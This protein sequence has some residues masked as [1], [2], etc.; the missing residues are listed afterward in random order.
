MAR[1]DDAAPL[2]D[3]SVPARVPAIASVLV[4]LGALLAGNLL[5]AVIVLV[6]VAVTR[7]PWAEVGIKRWPHW[8]RG[9]FMAIGAGALLKVALKV[10]V[11]PPL[12]M[13]PVNAAYHALTG[14]AAALPGILFLVV[15]GGGFGEELIWRGFLFERLRALLGSSPSARLLIVVFSSLLFGLAHL[16]DQGWP[17]VVQATITGAVFGAAFLRLSVIWPVMIAHASFDLTGV[18][19]IYF[20]REEW[21]ARLVWR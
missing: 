10:L 15:V 13:P 21:F 19:M 18:V 3:S 11:L 20:G 12:G 14:N 4:T 9:I 6:W 17:A 2:R 16:H 5:G 8:P 1:S 7:T